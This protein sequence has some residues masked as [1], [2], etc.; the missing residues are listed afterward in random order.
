MKNIT[1]FHTHILPGIDDGSASVEES[2]QLLNMLKEQGVRRVLFTPHFYPQR[3]SIEEFLSAREASL[4]KLTSHPDF[5]QD[6][7]Y[8]TA[9]EVYYN[10]AL[11]NYTQEELQKLFIPNTNF[12]LLEFPLKEKITPAV[13]Q[14]VI[15][16]I[17]NYDC[18]PIL[19]HIERYLSFIS[20]YDLEDLLEQGCRLQINLNSWEDLSFFKKRRL[21]RYIR[22]N[23]VDCCGTDCH[24]PD[25][26]PPAFTESAKRLEQ[27]V[28]SDYAGPII[29]AKNI[30]EANF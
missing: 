1:D 19:A 10:H 24:D 6:M 22:G 4:Q 23:W 20:N 16:L 17:Y 12:L 7:E 28:G 29:T 14:R 11:L 8:I 30:F 18:T 2:L 21:F 25:Y 3:T 9:A 5:P 13:C 26:R 27:A 15:Q